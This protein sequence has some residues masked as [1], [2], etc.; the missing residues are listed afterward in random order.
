MENQGYLLLLIKMYFWT[1]FVRL[2]T[3]LNSVLTSCMDLVLSAPISLHIYQFI[4]FCN[5]TGTSTQVDYPPD[6][7]L[8][9]LKMMQFLIR[10]ISLNIDIDLNSIF[11]VIREWQFI[12]GVKEIWMVYINKHRCKCVKMLQHSFLHSRASKIC[13]I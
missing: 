12:K 6:Q 11:D 10:D 8:C 1:I 5:Q 3:E 7:S 4:S 2:Y 9:Y 13:I